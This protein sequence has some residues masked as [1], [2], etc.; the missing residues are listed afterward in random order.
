MHFYGHVY[1]SPYYVNLICCF[2]SP[3]VTD[4]D[5]QTY[6][7]DSSVNTDAHSNAI[8]ESYA[9]INDSE[10]QTNSKSKHMFLFVFIIII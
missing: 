9:S 2:F 4:L 7:Y 10:S 8:T 1:N 3:C 6:E 5:D